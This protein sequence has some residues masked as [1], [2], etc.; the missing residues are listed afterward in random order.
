MRYVNGDKKH[1]TVGTPV[2]AAV[3]WSAFGFTVY[4]PALR[5]QG[6]VLTKEVFSHTMS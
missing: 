1:S 4:I 6:P 5:T 3:V 2:L